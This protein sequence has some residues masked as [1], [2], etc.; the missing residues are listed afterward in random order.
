MYDTGCL[1]E[2]ISGLYKDYFMGA[3]YG[4]YREYLG[5]IGKIKGLCMGYMR[6]AWGYIG[7]I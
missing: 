3:I 1:G 5:M 7:L 2:V 4:L 6:A